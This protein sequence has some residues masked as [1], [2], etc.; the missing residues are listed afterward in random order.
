[1]VM[2]AEELTLDDPGR[3]DIFIA[4]LGDRASDIAAEWLGKLRQLGFRSDRDYLGRSVKA[5]MRE[6]NRQQ[7]RIVLLIGDNEISNEVFTV[8]EM[9]H[10]EQRSVP[11]S[12]LANYLREYL[13]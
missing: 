1:M 5:Q 7:A 2:A 11:F 6:A 3:L 8:K 9:D 10:G 13:S 12:D 4:P